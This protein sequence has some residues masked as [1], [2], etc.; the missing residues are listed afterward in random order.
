MP[1]GG[2]TRASSPRCVPSHTTCACARASACGDG[3]PGED[4]PARAARHDHDRAA[5][6]S[7][8]PSL[9]EALLPAVQLVMNPQQEAERD[10]RDDG[11]RAA[12]ADQRQRQS[13][14]R[15]ADPELTP[16][17]TNASKPS[18]TPMPVA[19]RPWKCMPLSIAS[20]PSVI[21]R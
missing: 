3:E 13:L 1:C 8:V 16:M 2:T 20:R 6:S 7:H 18:M 21:A 14:R 9:H 11:A 4:V 17:L 19:T 12:V 15:Q 10:E 5:R